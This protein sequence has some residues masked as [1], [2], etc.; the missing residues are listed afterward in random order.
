MKTM[1]EFITYTKGI[2]YLIAICFIFG[3]F[4]Y[5]QFVHHKGKGLVVK[6]VPL[7]VLT[8][9][10]GGL[11]STCALKDVTAMGSPSVKDLPLLN[12]QVLGDIYGPATFDHVRHQSLVKDC[13]TC[14]HNGSADIQTGSIKSCNN[15][16]APFSVADLSKPSLEHTFHARCITCHKTVQAGPTQCTECHHEATVM[17]ISI[18]HPTTSGEDCLGC[19][20][21]QNT[22]PGV[23]TMP[24]DHKDATDG[25]CQLCH[26]TAA[27]GSVPL[28]AH[29]TVGQEDCLLCHKDVIGKATRIPADHAGKTNTDCLVCHKV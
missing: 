10:F 26:K 25:V 21:L 7:V 9:V 17:P 18:P 28:I 20:R 22:G 11:A 15:C 23:P 8:V 3:F 13:T 27:N 1:L 4:S 2:E 12:S 14:H 16:H 5:W 6:I 24:A 19:H 29:G